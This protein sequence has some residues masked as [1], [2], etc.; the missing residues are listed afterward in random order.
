MD[1]GASWSFAPD[2]SDGTAAAG[3]RTVRVFGT[4]AMS[5]NDLG[6]L[7]TQDRGQ[8]AFHRTS[9]GASSAAPLRS[10]HLPDWP[11]GDRCRVSHGQTPLLPG[12]WPWLWTAAAS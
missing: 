6:L 12:R 8:A 7:S 5:H 9:L 4:R 11:S 2:E 10:L 1:G 3:K